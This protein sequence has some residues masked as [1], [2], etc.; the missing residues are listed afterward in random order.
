MLKRFAAA[1]GLLACVLTPVVAASA[2]V[3]TGGPDA[4]LAALLVRPVTGET[5]LRQDR[6]DFAF[7]INRPVCNVYG[8]SPFGSPHRTGIDPTTYRLNLRIAQ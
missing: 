2:A 1:A 3:E 7:K 8:D 6:T 5:T 4:A